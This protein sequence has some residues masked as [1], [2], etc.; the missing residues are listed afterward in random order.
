MADPND[1]VEQTLRK[2]GRRHLVMPGLANRLVTLINTRALSR[3]RAVIT[4]GKFME[5]GLGKHTNDA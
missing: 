3:R 5:R 4:M 2:I 1:A